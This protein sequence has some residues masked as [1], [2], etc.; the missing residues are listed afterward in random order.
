MRLRAS[1]GNLSAKMHSLRHE[2]GVVQLAMD[3]DPFNPELREDLISFRLAYQQACNDA[4]SEARQRAKVRWLSEDDSNTHYFHNV[5]H[6]RCHS[7]NLFSVSDVNGNMVYDDDVPLAFIDHLKSFMGSRDTNLEPNMPQ[8][9]YHS[10]LSLSDAIHMVRPITDDE[11]KYAMFQIGN[12][13]A[14]GSD[15]FS[16]FILFIFV[17]IS[18]SSLL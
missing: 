8:D 17:V 10:R 16:S 2:L 1:Y 4:E 12:N 11:I 14:L 3:L 5:V 13:K 15:G 7:N 6:E 9:L 18:V